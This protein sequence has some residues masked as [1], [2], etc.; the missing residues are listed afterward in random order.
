M[1]IEAVEKSRRK[2]PHKDSKIARNHEYEHRHFLK[3]LYDLPPA[4][5][6]G[7]WIHGKEIAQEYVGGGLA[8]IEYENYHCSE[9]GYTVKNIRWN[10]DGE[11]MD[12]YCS[13]CGAEM[14]GEQNV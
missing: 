13:V 5:K 7:K 12:K 9:C 4:R 14:K 6:K 11:L 3:I 10:V 8:H 1:A 2:N